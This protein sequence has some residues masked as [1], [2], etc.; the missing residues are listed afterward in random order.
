MAWKSDYARY[1]S[2]NVRGF[3]DFSRLLAECSMLVPR[4]YGHPDLCEIR[5]R[6]RG[7]FFSSM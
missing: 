1:D 6:N 4:I 3:G 2:H 5:V 7:Y